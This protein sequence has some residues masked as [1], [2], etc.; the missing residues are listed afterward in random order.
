MKKIIM[1]IISCF[2]VFSLIGCGDSSSSSSSSSNLTS[3]KRITLSDDAPV[4][5]SKENVDKMISFVQNNNSKGQQEMIQ[6]GEATILP[7]GTEVNIVKSGIVIEIETQ[8]GTRW[9]APEE[10]IKD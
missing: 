8:N 3:G 6:R 5:S 2:M 1:I 4:C 10:A 9:F 7:K